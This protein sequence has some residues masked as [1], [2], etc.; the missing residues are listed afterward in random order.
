MKTFAQYVRLATDAISRG[1]DDLASD[2]LV[3]AEE[4]RR[5]ADLHRISIKDF[6]ASQ[7]QEDDT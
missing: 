4:S 1:A 3:L 2:F 5:R 6:L 7:L